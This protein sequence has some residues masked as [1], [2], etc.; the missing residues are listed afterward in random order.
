M[1]EIEEGKKETKDKRDF[2]HLSHVIM[3]HNI[4]K[5]TSLIL[6]K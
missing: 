2:L 4:S 3:K 6:N 1:T 5:K